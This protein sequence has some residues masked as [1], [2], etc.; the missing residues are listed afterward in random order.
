MNATT[1]P[2][3]HQ[4]VIPQGNGYLSTLGFDHAF[5]ETQLLAERLGRP[6]LAPFEAERG[7]LAVLDKRKKLLSL[8]AS[9]DTLGTWFA[10]NTPVAVQKLI[11]RLIHSGETVRI[12]HG[13]RKTG[14]SWM[15]ENDVIGRV[16]RSTGTLKIPLLVSEQD[17]YGGALLEDSIIRVIRC[18]DGKNLYRHP[19]FHVPPMQ[20]VEKEHP[21]Y[22]ASV[23][24]EGVVAARFKSY[25]KACHWVAFMAGET[26]TQ[27]A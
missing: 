8:A 20:I 25:G 26:V 15:E 5:N 14:R 13:D 11:N 16:G 19:G 6:D 27:P 1:N 22:A 17:N 23:L 9:S 7:T 24:V 3:A 10:P 21:Q 18:S 2:E 12:F 4:Y